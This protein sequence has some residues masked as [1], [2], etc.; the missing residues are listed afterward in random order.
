LSAAADAKLKPKIQ[1]GCY[2]W[3]AGYLFS[4][5]FEQFKPLDPNYLKIA[6]LMP[7]VQ[8]PDQILVTISFRFAQIIE[9]TPALRDHF[10]QA[11]P[12]RMIFPVNLEVLSQML[13]P[14]REKR[15]LHIRAAGIF[16]M[17]LELLEIQRLVTLSH[18]EGPIVAEEPIFAT[19]Q[20]AR[21][22]VPKPDAALVCRRTKVRALYATAH[23][24]DP[25][26]ARQRT[27]AKI[28][29]A[30]TCAISGLK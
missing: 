4:C 19:S 16:V 11:A 27:R 22:R 6:R 26:Q 10:E 15:D 7:K 20:T 30:N 5:G 25:G 3:T 9:Q 1:G 8:L 2:A 28:P 29:Y 17:Q 14:V 12:R 18:N 13:D 21:R 23:R 24:A